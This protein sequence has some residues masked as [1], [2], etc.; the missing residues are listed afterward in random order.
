MYKKY[1][2]DLAMVHPAFN[3]KDR[4]GAHVSPEAGLIWL[5]SFQADPGQCTDIGTVLCVQ[6]LL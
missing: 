2:L 5:R 4:F 6:K 3:R 1:D